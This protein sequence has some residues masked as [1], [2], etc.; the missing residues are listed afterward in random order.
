MRT[1]HLLLVTS[2][3]SLP[4][5]V[6]A[7]TGSAEQVVVYGPLSGSSVGLQPGMVAA[8]VQ[9]LTSS[10]IEVFHGTTVLDSLDARVAGVSLS[11]TQG[12][13]MFQNVRY[14]G[15]EASPLQGNAQG[16]AVYQNGMRLNEAFGDTVNWDAIPSAAIDRTDVW[17]SNPV[18]GL[19]ALGGAVNLIMKDGFRWQG[20]T[21]SVQGGDYGQG[22]GVLQYGINDGHFGFYGALEGIADGGYRQHSASDVGRFY[23]D[24][25]WRSDKS[26]VHLAASDAVSVLGVVG[27]TPVELIQQ[28]SKSVYTWPQKTDNQVGALALRGKTEVAP[29]WQVEAS[30][31]VRDFRQNHIDGNDADFERCSAKSSFGGAICL[32]DDAFAAPPGG[33]T[34]AFRD[35]FVIVNGAGQT[36]P[37]TNGVTY[38]TVDR[39]FTNAT[40]DGGAVQ[41]TSDS[42]LFGFSNYLTFGT[43]I[44]HSD[45]GF[46]SNSILGRIYPDLKVDLD[47]ALP[48]SGNIIRTQGDLGYAPVD[49]SGTVNYYGIYAVNALNLTEGLTLT[50]GFRGNIAN[51]ET[52]DN[53]GRA[54][55]LTATHGFTHFN[56]MAGVTYALTNEVSAFAGYSQANRAPTLLE[57]DCASQSQ[58]CLLE[59]SLVADP[60]LKQVV[61]H[62]YEAGLRGG[63][64]WNGGRLS[65]SASLFRTDSDNDIV[66]LASA[67]QGRGFFSNVPSTRRQG[68][69]LT[70]RIEAERWSAYASYSYLDATFQFSGALASPNNPFAD[71]NGNIFVAP[72]NRIP[73]NPAHHARLGGELEILPGLSLGADILI[74]GSQYYAGDDANQNEKLPAYWVLNLRGSYR[75]RDGWEAFALINNV[76]DRHDATYATF[77]D[78][79]GTSNLLNPPLIDARTL[80]LER[81]ISFQIGL[82]I[83]L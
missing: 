29:N 76:F 27:P 20:A 51:F 45:I 12:N 56:P 34:P 24:A 23:F 73:L 2:A 79:S 37:F 58:P 61:S 69:D 62:T 42:A 8:Q 30:A 80:T 67:I 57:V 55:E 14:H 52:H 47:A 82:T 28:A 4:A 64:D 60:P 71:A 7:Q 16:L 17:S 38:G 35:Q 25:G 66:A 75:F 46:R 77:F 21:A 65:W 3:L 53:T 6:M 74:T 68:I 11:D 63:S 48:G 5:A 15:F 31:Y 1:R 33:K 32:Q 78:P 50:L 44:D 26:E 83:K 39:T 22:I 81:P 10:Q 59:G 70:G 72:G 54:P 49:L 18:F 19:N 40:T 13:A 9:S 43:S 36:F 41:I